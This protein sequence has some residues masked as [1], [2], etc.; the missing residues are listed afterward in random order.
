[1]HASA[2]SA[3]SGAQCR[4]S[5]P[6]VFDSLSGHALRHSFVLHSSQYCYCRTS[7][8]QKHQKN[9]TEKG[10]FNPKFFRH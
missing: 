6:L 5:M 3:S 8:N 2:H 4:H 1:L 7:I 10:L 9:R